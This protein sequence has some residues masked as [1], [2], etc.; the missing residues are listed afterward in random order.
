MS[1]SF[2]DI[3]DY[4]FVKKCLKCGN[5]SLKN[6]FYK[7]KNMSDGLC[8]QFKVCRKQYYTE[9]L[10]KVKKYYLDN[11]D[12][13]K[14]YYLNNRDRIKEYQLKN[15]VKINLYEK[16][17]RET[18]DNFRLIKSAR[19]QIYHALKGRSKSSST[20][21]ILGIDIDLHKK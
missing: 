18:D 10:V 4:D 15:R 9:N 3:F 6:N 5:I 20:K 11:R 14:D 12:R 2:K 8:N 16:K 7:N 17:R 19:C 21:Q 13:T 1:G